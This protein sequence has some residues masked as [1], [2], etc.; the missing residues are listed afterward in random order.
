MRES[1]RPG[2]TV[3]R[4]GGD[5]FVVIMESLDAP[6]DAIEVVNSV[7]AALHPRFAAANGVSYVSASIG[8]A[9]TNAEKFDPEVLVRN[10]D[11]AMYHAKSSGKS[12]YALFQPDMNDRLTERVELELGLRLA[13]EQHQFRG[14]YQPLVDLQTG[15]LAGVEALV[16]WQHPEK[17][18]IAP[19]KFIPIAE[20]N[21][22]IIPLGYW[23]MEE[24]CRKQSRGDRRIPTMAHSS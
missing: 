1:V 6:E 14:C 21:G 5:E 17:G 13:L 2:D 8:I 23:V 15:H 11:T 10:A 18:L 4:F 9:F 16:R 20:E 3:A 7:S 22:L 12:A 24:A 19:G